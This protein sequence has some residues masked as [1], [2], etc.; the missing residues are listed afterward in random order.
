MK[1]E[2]MIKRIKEIIGNW[3]G[4]T[5]GEL[6]LESSPCINSIGNGKNNVSQLVEYFNAEDVTAITYQDELELGEEDIIYEDLK[7]DI[8]EEILGIME[9]YDLKMKKENA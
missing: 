2:K 1:R 5:A 6:E 4:T 7:D 9:N 8:L 3:G